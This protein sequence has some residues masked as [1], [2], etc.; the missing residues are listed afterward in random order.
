MPAYRNRYW[1]GKYVFSI[2]I[3][4]LSI[5]LIHH[6]KLFAEQRDYDLYIEDNLENSVYDISIPQ[7]ESFTKDYKIKPYDYQI[8]FVHA[9]RTERS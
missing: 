3:Q 7:L 1:D 2:L 4:S 6:I 5:A 8:A 9:L